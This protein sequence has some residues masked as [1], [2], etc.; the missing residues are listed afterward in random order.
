MAKH[1]ESCWRQDSFVIWEGDLIMAVSYKKLWKLLIDKD[2]K[3]KDLSAKAGISPATITKMGKGGHVTTE[4][5][6]KIC[7]A[8]ACSIDD[9]MEILPN[10]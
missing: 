4:V 8:L 9:I 5:L 7:A 6:A 2:I 10:N 3:K 1:R